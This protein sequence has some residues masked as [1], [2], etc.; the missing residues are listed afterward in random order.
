[1]RSLRGQKL[2]LVQPQLADGRRPDGPP[3][4]VVDALGAGMG[5][6][7][8]ITSD[9]RGARELLGCHQDARALD[10]G[11]DSKTN[12]GR[13]RSIIEWLV[14]EVIRRLQQAGRRAAP[15]P[16]APRR[17]PPRQSAAAPA[18]T[19]HRGR[20]PGARSRVVTLAADRTATGQRAARA[21]PAGGRRD[22]LGQ[23]R[24]AQTAHPSRVPRRI[25]CGPTR[26]RRN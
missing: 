2:L 13:T 3:L 17:P 14:A 1:M 4:L 20:R 18:A 24:T 16:A 23:R 22:T 8:M 21:R 19:S 10:D 12:D 6:T 25:G 11:G 5:E 7:V 26:R 15:S 9:G